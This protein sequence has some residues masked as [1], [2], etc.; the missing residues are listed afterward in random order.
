[1]EFDKPSGDF[2]LGLC[3]PAPEDCD[4]KF[5]AFLGLLDDGW[6]FCEDALLAPYTSGGEKMFNIRRIN[7]SRFYFLALRRAQSIFD[8]G[9]SQI[10]HL[11]ARGWTNESAANQPSI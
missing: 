7:A 5:S 4:T 8:K 6:S 11:Q 2:D 10:I 3:L 9:A 1:M